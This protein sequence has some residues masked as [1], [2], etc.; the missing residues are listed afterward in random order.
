MD[1]KDQKK[2]EY[3]DEELD[4]QALLDKYLPDEEKAAASH[5]PESK[6]SDNE[7]YLENDVHDAEETEG[8]DTFLFSGEEDASLFDL[9][10][11]VE[12][13]V[14]YATE[15]P[16]EFF[17]E[18]ED[19]PL[20]ESSESVPV[21]PVYTSEISEEKAEDLKEV[22]SS[23]IFVT[24]DDEEFIIDEDL[25]AE[26]MA[27]DTPQFGGIEGFEDIETLSGFDST[28]DFE[29]VSAEE[30]PVTEEKTYS[31]KT[32]D[33]YGEITNEDEYDE[34]V[35]ASLDHLES[36]QTTET[37]INLLVAFGLEDE[38]KKQVGEKKVSRMTRTFDEKVEAHDE[39]ERRTV[40]NEY[41]DA[42]QT[43]E[44]SE[45]Y[46]KEYVSLKIK[47]GL[48]IVFAA[49]LLVFENLPVIGYQFASFLDPAVYPVVYTMVDLQLLL[50][51]LAPAYDQIFY[52]F[53]RLFK[54][55]PTPESILS[56]TA[57]FSLAYS[58]MIAQ[59][60]T[61]PAEPVM[62]NLPVALCSVMTLIYSYLTVKREIFS[63]N[64]ISSKKPKFALRRLSPK[65]ATMEV[66]AFSDSEEEMGDVLKIEKTNFIDCYF[67][68][69][70]SANRSNSAII[71][72]CL[73]LALALAALF[74]TY[75]G[76]IR[77]TVVES[78]EM[79]Y[80]AFVAAVPLTVLLSYSFPFYKANLESYE[81]DSTIIG[82]NSLEEYSGASVISFDDKLVFPSVGVKVQNIK[83]YNNYRFDRVLYYAASVFAKTGGPLA[84]I[85]EIATLE[86]GYSED[87]LLTG[88]GDGYLQTEVDGKSIMFG[89]AYDLETLG[90]E[91]PDEIKGDDEETDE[92]VSV[93]YMVFKGK[94]VA[95]MNILYALD[96]DFE[97]IVKQLAGSGMS[98][99]VKTLDPNI[100]EEMIKSRV[101]LDK[102][103][104]RV[105]RYASL[106][107]VAMETERSDSGI[108]A[109][110]SSGA[111]LRTV[112]YCDKVL[113]V[114]RTTSFIGLL[115]TI[116][117][118]VILAVVLLTGNMTSVRSVFTLLNHLFWM[119]PVAIT[120]KMLVR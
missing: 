9:V 104:M 25:I 10:G 99:C 87:V 37:D 98:V 102:Y 72:M 115:A 22:E 92:N 107:E 46:K 29:E 64:V 32:P 86:M 16:A 74:G 31:D 41:R 105:I 94:P 96:S 90:I 13:A 58:V 23:G 69:T 76:M 11:D 53:A 97:Y 4:L 30:A 80:I 71:F 44:I 24:G 82:E 47:L 17:E 65:D 8:D 21:Q 19:E 118:V 20:F 91:I 89:R 120:T 101:K 116:I 108:V 39:K 33:K 34:F 52:G 5:A 103:P 117:T 85:F 51:C 106:D 59:T 95:K 6:E 84:D 27:D 68:R 57:L 63:F 50:L 114:K 93:M 15:I 54:G 38:L 45:K 28:S 55:K 26:L 110:G 79:G 56:V 3:N 73:I 48:S 2:T 70:E 81:N 36:G 100:D 43:K 75:V 67:F 62:F 40:E 14:E 113:E 66:A 12:E 88:I 109:R 7:F 111:L 18:T 61:P 60:A 42:S 49:L 77:G 1:H 112:T 35:H 78:L 119:I 83:I